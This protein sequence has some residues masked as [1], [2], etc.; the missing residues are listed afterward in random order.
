[1]LG[2][3]ATT[4]QMPAATKIHATIRRFRPSARIILGG[5]H[6]TLVHAAAKHER[7]R[8][9]L[10]RASRAIKQLTAMFD[11]LVTGDGEIAV[12]EALQNVPPRIVDGDDPRSQFFLSNT[13]LSRC[14]FRRATWLTSPPTNTVLT[15]Q[16]LSL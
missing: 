4:P 15:V 6:V 8:S 16:G 10:G 2:I 14:H 12:F 9:V 3:T 1:M 5:P 11:V 7:K 13:S